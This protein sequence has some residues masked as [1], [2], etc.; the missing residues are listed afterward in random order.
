[1]H[2]AS[3]QCRPVH[4]AF[5]AA[6][7]PDQTCTLC[8]PFTIL[9]TLALRKI[10]LRRR[11][12]SGKLTSVPIVTQLTG[13]NRRNVTL[14][15]FWPSRCPIAAVRTGMSPYPPQRH[16]AP[17]RP[18]GPEHRVRTRPAAAGMTGHETFRGVP[19][20]ARRVS[21][22]VILHAGR[23][24]PGAM[25][26]SRKLSVTRLGERS[27]ACAVRRI[28]MTLSGPAGAARRGLLGADRAEGSMHGKRA[29]GR[30]GPGDVG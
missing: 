4:P 15:R 28:T 29:Q 20:A 1:M 27:R 21:M 16:N 8:G 22:S 13:R 3:G 24:S 2:P 14:R 11:T 17:V 9:I 12:E 30:P 23:T 26:A 5:P 19:R 18:G 7:I 25:R 10:G 6:R